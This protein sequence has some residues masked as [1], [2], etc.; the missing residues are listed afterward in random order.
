M[1]SVLVLRGECGTVRWLKFE[2]CD[3]KKNA[4]TDEDRRR[5]SEFGPCCF[6]R[7]ARDVVVSCQ[8]CVCCL[9]CLSEL[10]Q[11]VLIL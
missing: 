2:L 10:D 11:L 7:L 8:C 1:R 9:L 6:V 4:F 3:T 5:G